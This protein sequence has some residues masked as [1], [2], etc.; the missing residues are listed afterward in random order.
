MICGRPRF[1]KFVERVLYVSGNSSI[2]KFSLNCRKGY[3]IKLWLRDVLNRG[4]L[5]D[6]D[7]HL[8]VADAGLPCEVFTCN[9]LV[10]LKLTE[11]CMKELPEDASLPALKKLF[12]KSIEFDSLQ[13][14]AFGKLL[15]ACPVLEEL[16]LDD[17]RWDLWKWSRSVFS[18]SLR[19]LTF[20]HTEFRDYY[21]LVPSS[22]L[23]VNL[24][25]LVEA[26]LDLVGTI[27]HYYNSHLAGEGDNI[28]SNPTDMFKEMR[29][30]QI[31]NLLSQNSLEIFY[32]FRGVIPVYENMFHL[33]ITTES[34]D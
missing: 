7:L 1:L 18:P 9:T 4:G 14:C 13:L 33:S 26:N 28:T 17:L 20:K 19:K 30:V 12:L 8:D 6:P 10:E 27:G 15:S 32:L 34:T 2:K 11:F 29:N 22:Y 31:M 23:A 24:N 3:R 16:V 21:D 5:L 25:S